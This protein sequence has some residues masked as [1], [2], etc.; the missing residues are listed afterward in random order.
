MEIPIN[1]A[2][3]LF[4]C[5]DITRNLVT[6]SLY[7]IFTLYASKKIREDEMWIGQRFAHMAS[8]LISIWVIAMI[9]AP[10]LIMSVLYPAL[11]WEIGTEILGF[12]IGAIILT[13]IV[14]I[15]FEL[16][17][18]KGLFQKK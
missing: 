3:D 4:S 10:F 2:L 12:S 13:I 9:V 18:Y 1:V 14:V 11:A 17:Q 16:L 15:V 6:L 8:L 5:M 7:S